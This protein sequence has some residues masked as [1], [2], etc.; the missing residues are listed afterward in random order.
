M[1][2]DV[3]VLVRKPSCHCSCVHAIACRTHIPEA[4]VKAM[5]MKEGSHPWIFCEGHAHEKGEVHLG[6]G[7]MLFTVC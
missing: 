6:H 4:L 3:R 7:G 2:S 1:C 5:L